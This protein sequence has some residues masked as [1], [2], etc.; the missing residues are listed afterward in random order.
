M[1]KT[2]NLK[3]ILCF[4][5]H[6][7]VETVRQSFLGECGQ[8]C[9]QLCVDQVSNTSKIIGRIFDGYV[10]HFRIV[11]ELLIN[12]FNEFGANA[13]PLKRWQH[14]HLTDSWP[15]IFRIRVV[16]INGRKTNG[17]VSCLTQ[18]VCVFFVAKMGVEKNLKI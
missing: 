5:N 2:I 3:F 15:H 11:A 13:E 14:Q 6:R 16:Q 17:C 10:K 18:T 9:A 1:A 7:F 8:R 4:G 12:N